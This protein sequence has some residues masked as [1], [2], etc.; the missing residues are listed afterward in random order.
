MTS[1]HLWTSAI[2]LVGFVD[3]PERF[4]PQM[5][6]NKMIPHEKTTPCQVKKISLVYRG[7][8]KM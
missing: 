1:M 7:K 3:N 5:F 2:S 8:E 4:P 6:T